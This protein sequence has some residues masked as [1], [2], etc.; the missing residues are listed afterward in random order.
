MC[1]H[2]QA[3]LAALNQAREHL[4]TVQGEHP[5]IHVE[6]TPEAI[7]RVVSDWTGIPV[8]KLAQEQA[9]MVANLGNILA[10]RIK[11]QNP[12]LQAV[13]QGIQA[14]KA[15]LRAVEQP[16]GVFLL[17]G[18]SGVGKTETGL[19]L[20]DALFGDERSIITI[21]MSEF[22]EKHTVSRLIGSPPGYVG[23]GEGGMLTEAVRRRP[24][25]VVLLDEVEKAHTD[26]MQLFYQ[27]FDKGTLTDGEGT[28]IN[29]RNTVL[30]LTSNLASDLV[31][32]L[33]TQSG[34]TL[35]QESLSTTIRPVLSK[36]FQ[37]ALLARMT[38]VPYMS[39]TTEALTRITHLK[40]SALVQR[41]Y[42]NN[43]IR[44][45]YDDAVPAAIASR[46]VEVETGARNIDYILSANILPQLSRRILENMADGDMP[47]EVRLEFDEEGVLH[48]HF[49]K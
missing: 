14:G 1:L 4:A 12:A 48:M 15:G 5:L 20:A 3:A 29:F 44:L 30:M 7:G 24:Y 11:G 9:S 32:E 10:Q 16:L 43:K 38:I 2:S 39:L 22:Q 49:V 35:S 19:A 13:V 18:P 45:V 34:E 36:H 33:C 8:G 21:N 40:L 6:V 42:A 46:C 37:P 41:L 28:E 23:Y 25:S 27:V 47:S 31:Q 17:V 26:V